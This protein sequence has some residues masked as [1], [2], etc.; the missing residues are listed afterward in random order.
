MGRPPF[1][2]M[3]IL[4]WILGNPAT[5]GCLRESTFLAPKEASSSSLFS[6]PVFSYIYDIL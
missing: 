5:P 6:M 3:F 2:L 4:V 1:M